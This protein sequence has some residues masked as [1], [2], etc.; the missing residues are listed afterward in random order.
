LVGGTFDAIQLSLEAWF[1]SIGQNPEPIPVH[2]ELY[3]PKREES[4]KAL[5]AGSNPRWGPQEALPQVEQTES[6][7]RD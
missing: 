6:R 4:L 5:L 1:R 7:R 3:G 2:G